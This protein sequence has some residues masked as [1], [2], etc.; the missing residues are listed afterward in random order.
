M[1]VL[2]TAALAA[3]LLAPTA[4]ATAG[5][6]CLRFEGTSLDLTITNGS[7]VSEST[8]VVVN[9]CA[10]AVTAR[11]RLIPRPGSGNQADAT[12]LR[13]SFLH[14]GALLHDA[15]WSK[16]SSAATVLAVPAGSSL[17][18]SLHTGLVAGAVRPAAGTYVADFALDWIATPDGSAP[19]APG[20]PTGVL[21]V[22][23]ADPLPLLGV[24]AVG[25][26]LG[27]TI[28]IFGVRRRSDHQE[29]PDVR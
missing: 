14:G 18:L 19:G 22:T 10:A 23:G 29:S 2:L 5:D 12:S 24:G 11:L 20:G 16:D 13:T 8:A 15:S 21:G 26:A 4:S 27:A 3:G 28:L 9:D 6:A 1:S 7:E 17:R 25:A